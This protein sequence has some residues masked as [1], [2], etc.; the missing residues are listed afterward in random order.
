TP[1]PFIV[2]LFPMLAEVE[3]NDSP[4][5]GQHMTLPVTLV[6][7]IGRAGSVDYYR[8]EAEAGQ[9]IGVQVLT[10]A[11]GSKL[12][13]VLVLIDDAG[14]T[15]AEG[16]KGVLG[17]NCEKART[18]A[19]GVRDRDYRGG[20]EMHYRLHV[21]EI[22]VITSVF[23]LG[24]QRGTEA[25][26]GVEGVHLGAV[27]AVRIRA[28][29]DATVGSK[30][31][32]TLGT[33][34]GKPLGEASVVVGEFPE[35]TSLSQLAHPSHRYLGLPMLPVPGT[36]NGR[37]EAPGTADT[38]QFAAKKGQPL[39][40]EV[41][42]RRLGSPLDSYIEILDAAGKLV[43]RATL[44]CVAKTYVTFRDH[45]SSLPGIRIENWNQLAMNDYV[46]VGNELLRIRELP[47]TPDDDC[48]FFN[49]NRQRVAYLGTTPTHIPQ[50][51]PMY[52][53]T[54][55]PPGTTFPPNGFPVIPLA[56]RNDDG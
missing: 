46:W 17:Y 12:D 2:D 26:I 20:K 6:G 35:V 14:R 48:E 21:G 52:K 34:H 47:K 31:P 7:A 5:T 33:P 24:L 39:I 36:A 50:G 11:I 18:Y 23:P 9:A 44:R 15:V 8:F 13:P 25:L 40:V 51:V 4:K 43:P 3:P 32:V 53:V 41:E 54:I 45:D 19:L 55:H 29:A 30:L 22:P 49:V 1:L 28:D 56:Y 10:S 42:A 16:T 27:Q 38:W 37:I